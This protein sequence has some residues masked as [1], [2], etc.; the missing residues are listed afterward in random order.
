MT[1]YGSGV[2]VTVW[3]VPVPLN[4]PAPP[5]FAFWKSAPENRMVWLPPEGSTLPENNPVAME[6]VILNGVGPETGVTTLW[7]STPMVSEKAA[8]RSL[9]ANETVARPDAP[10]FRTVL[11]VLGATYLDPTRC[12]S[13]EKPMG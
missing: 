13:P 5:R 10:K 2:S 11:P 3:V 1:S 12:V 8:A 4:K 7:V 6:M 9:A